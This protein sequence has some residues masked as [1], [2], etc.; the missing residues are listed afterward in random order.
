MPVSSVTPTKPP[1][2]SVASPLA[3]SVS[4][5]HS[6][7]SSETPNSDRQRLEGILKASSAGVMTQPTHTTGGAE[8]ASTSE[9][10]Y[11]K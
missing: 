6:R 4:S 9:V 7:E 8:T 3:R 1:T 10:S 5:V 11:G 2:V